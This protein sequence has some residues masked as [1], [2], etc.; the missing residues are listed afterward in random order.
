MV[1]YLGINMTWIIIF[2]YLKLW[3]IFKYE[4]SQ[5]GVV[6]LNWNKK[7]QVY[8]VHKNKFYVYSVKSNEEDE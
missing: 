1:H 4:I 8:I 3:I 6:I 5:V 7:N 2:V